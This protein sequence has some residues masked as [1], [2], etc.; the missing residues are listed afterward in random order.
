MYKC[1]YDGYLFY[2]VVYVLLRCKF[3]ELILHKYMH[4]YEFTLYHVMALI[5][6]D[7]FGM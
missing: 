2:F 7:C 4:E 3:Y 1:L 5:W 6:L